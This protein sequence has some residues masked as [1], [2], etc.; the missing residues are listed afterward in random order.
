VVE[1]ETQLT[2]DLAG[3]L[4]RFGAKIEQSVIFSG[5]AAMARVIYDEVKL[6]TSGARMKKYEA[7]F[8]GPHEQSPPG[9]KT[10][11]LDSAIYRVYSPELSSD[12]VKT[13]KISV[14]HVK[15]PHFWLIEF[16]WSRA[17]AHPYIRPA[18]DHI[19]DAIKAG[20]ARM[21][22]VLAEITHAGG[23]EALLP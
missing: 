4:D 6:N 12:T 10:G 18:F 13:Y 17:P 7:G 2:G 21:A 19:G 3:D 20:Q 22:G 16:G 11:T 1:I 5:A 9:R 8:I 23:G 15:A 14:N